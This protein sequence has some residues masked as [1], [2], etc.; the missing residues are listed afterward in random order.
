MIFANGG[1]IAVKDPGNTLQMA[2]AVRTQGDSA[3]A[4]A[5]T[6]WSSSFFLQKSDPFR[7][8]AKN[9]IVNQR[10]SGFIH[11]RFDDVIPHAY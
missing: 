6:D 1:R 3:L 2:D 11:V 4:Y 8:P 5:T 7:A 9:E 10:S